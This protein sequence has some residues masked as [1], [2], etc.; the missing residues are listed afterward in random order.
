ML[1]WTNTMGAQL[2]FYYIF[3][4]SPPYVPLIPLVGLANDLPFPGGLEDRRNTAM[5]EFRQKMIAFIH[6]YDPAVPEQVEQWEL[7]IET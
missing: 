5:V 6:D 2:S 7:C 3:V 1:P 4:F